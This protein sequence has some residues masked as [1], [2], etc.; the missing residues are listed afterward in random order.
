MFETINVDWDVDLH[1]EHGNNKT[2]DQTSMHS[3]RMRTAR[4]LTI[5]AGSLPSLEG[6][7]VCLPGGSAFLPA[8]PAGGQNRPPPNRRA[9][10]PARRADPPSGGQTAP[11]HYDHVTSDAFWE[12][13]DPPC[14]DRCL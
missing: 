3:S 1:G 11:A 2:Y 13:A 8:C 7:G 4:T 6:G 12:E 10:P 9:D 5:L 14:T